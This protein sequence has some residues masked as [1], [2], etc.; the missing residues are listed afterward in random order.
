M[1]YK[2]KEIDEVKYLID[3]NKEK[4]A[5]KEINDNEYEALNIKEDFD[6]VLYFNKKGKQKNIIDILGKR[7]I[8]K[9]KI[10]GKYRRIWDPKTGDIYL[11]NNFNNRVLIKKCIKNRY[12][13]VLTIKEAIKE[14]EIALIDF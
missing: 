1:E 14:L 7:K 2:I 4:I 9:V 5:L 12:E 6:K 13:T 10:K 3:K 8:R 11:Q